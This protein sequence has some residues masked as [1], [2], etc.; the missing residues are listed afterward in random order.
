MLDNS[1]ISYGI[2]ATS[3]KYGD[4]WNS[5][6]HIMLYHQRDG[7]GNYILYEATML[8][9]YDRVAHTARSASSVES[10]YHSIRRHNINEDV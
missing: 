3:L 5:S 1:N 6:G 9:S 7:Y 2:S 10:S 4:A 8:N